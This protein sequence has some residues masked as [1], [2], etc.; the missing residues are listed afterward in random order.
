MNSSIIL[1]IIAVYFGVLLLISYFTGKK[2]SSNDAFFLGNRQSPWII[3]SIGMI[4]TSLSGVTFVSVPGMV[5][6]IDMTY[7]QTVFGFFFGYILIAKVLLPLYYKL[8]LTSIY[9]YLDGRIGKRSYKTGASFFLLSKIVG[10]AARLYLVVLILQTYVFSA[11]NI[12]FWLTTVLSIALVWLYTYRSGIKTIV[13]TDTLQALCLIAMLIVIIWQVKD[14][15]DLS[16]G[17]MVQTLTESPHF[18]IF[19]F[20]DWHS[21]QHFAK[22]FFSGIFITIVMTGLDQDMMQKNLS[23][24]SLKDAQKNMYTYGF[25]FTP[26]NFLFLSLGVLLLTLA[27]QQGIALPALNDDILPMFCTSGILGNS[28]LI[29]FTIGI[30]AAAFSSADSALTA[31]TTSF[32]IDILGVEREEAEKAKR[33]RLKVHLMISVLFAV[34]ILIFKAVNS[35]SVIDAIYMIASYT[36]GPLLGLFLFGLFTKKQTRDKYVPYIC[37]AS[38][39]ICFTIDYLVKQYTTYVFSY[40]MLMINGAITFAGLWFASKKK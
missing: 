9:S 2:N 26:V 28:I 34:I 31:L 15:M 3:V 10:A 36:Y 13:W 37:I 29:F 11:W 4:G 24:K 8:Q 38:P 19:E 14:T 25:A 5:R 23:C 16:M 30:I 40:E 33:T 22:Q 1:V 35:R 18:R 12:P 20:R 21:T 39:L 6:S 7:M 32:C 27:A 17:G